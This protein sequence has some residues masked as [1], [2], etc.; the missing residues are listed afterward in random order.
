MTLILTTIFGLYLLF[1]L[2]IDKPRNNK[3]YLILLFSIITVSIA[4]GLIDPIHKN[5]S[6]AYIDSFLMSSSLFDHFSFEAV[7][8]GLIAYTEKGFYLLTALIHTFTDSPMVYYLIITILMFLL[9]YFGLKEYSIYP[10]IGFCIYLARYMTGRNLAQI[11]AGIAIAVIVLATKYVTE[12]KLWKFLLMVFIAFQF[13]HSALVALPLYFISY[14][15][16][17]KWHIVTTLLVALFVASTYGE[18]IYTLISNI[19][20]I[21]DMAGEYANKENGSV[22]VYD[23]GIS[24]PMIYY[25]MLILLP[26]T[27]ADKEIKQLTPHYYVLRDGLFLST[28]LLIL[29][30][31]YGTLAGRTSTV[32]ATYD[33]FMAPLLMHLSQKRYKI[34]VCFILLLVYVVLFYRN[35]Y[36]FLNIPNMFY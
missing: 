29:L 11:R 10:L 14:L 31:Q 25:Q 18:I 9:T 12:R 24:N 26:F 20:F 1:C 34:I 8:Q 2:I 21:Q 22:W 28:L 33:M 7:D 19:D 35:I 13:H 32:L 30:C 17:K 3:A 5:D 4:L 16:L 27:F 23:A 6:S 15:K 36:Q